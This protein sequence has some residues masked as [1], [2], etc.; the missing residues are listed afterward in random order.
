MPAWA[1]ASTAI[2]LS[3]GRLRPSWTSVLIPF[4]FLSDSIGQDVLRDSIY[5]VVRPGSGLRIGHVENAGNG[6]VTLPSLPSK[7]PFVL[8]VWICKGLHSADA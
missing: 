1:T 8:A 5:W 2:S 3:G 7:H 6:A 4:E